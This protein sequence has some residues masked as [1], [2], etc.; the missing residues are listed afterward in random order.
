M[1]GLRQGGGAI[2][3]LWL[4]E[5]RGRY[6]WMSFDLKAKLADALFRS[7]CREMEAEANRLLE[8]TL[9]ERAARTK[10]LRGWEGECFIDE[11]S[12]EEP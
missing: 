4:L 12:E 10:R 2:C 3:D 11:G 6:V 7:V 5:V 9:M 8:R 1:C